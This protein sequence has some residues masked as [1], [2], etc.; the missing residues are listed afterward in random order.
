MRIAAISDIHGMLPTMPEGEVDLVVIAGDIMP[1]LRPIINQR[2]WLDND[3]R[4]WLTWFP[5]RLP[6]V[7]TWGNHDIYAEGCGRDCPKL[8]WMIGVDMMFEVDGKK[9]YTFPWVPNLPFWAYSGQDDIRP[10]LHAHMIP[11]NIDILVSHGP[12]RG[13]SDEVPGAHHVGSEAILK[14]CMETKPPVMICGHIHEGRGKWA[15]PWGG[16]LY[17]VASIGGT[18]MKFKPYP[19]RWTYLE[20]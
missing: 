3:F 12:P 5:A 8:P 1:D 17:N 10:A 20:V 19:E 14:R 18:D 11:E 9:I 13:I 15:T 2:E 7:A 4:N 6:I 16:T